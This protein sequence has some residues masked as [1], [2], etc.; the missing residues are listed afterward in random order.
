M[1]PNRLEILNE[2]ADKKIRVLWITLGLNLTVSLAKIILGFAT[3]LLNIIAD[4][5]HSAG[6]TTSNIIGIFGIKYS[7]KPPDKKYPYGYSKIE[8]VASLMIGNILIIA[9]ALMLIETKDRFLNPKNYSFGTA[10]FA[11]MAAT[12]LIN[13]FVAIYELK[14][15][16]ELKSD[17]LKS[18]AKHTITDVLIS[19]SVIAGLAVIKLKG[20]SVLD[21]IMSAA[22]A[23]LIGK[24]VWGIYKDAI[25]ILC[26][27]N[28]I[29]QERIRELALSVP[30]I[31][32]CHAERSRGRPDA[33]FIELHILVNRLMTVGDA[34]DGV[35]HKV[36]DLFQREFGYGLQ[37]LSTHIEPDTE[38]ARGRS[39]SIFKEGDY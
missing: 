35:S 28:Y 5:I 7:K 15:S 2:M 17:F 14:K 26:D 9:M 23:V 39:K 22:I 19:T 25:P 38:E 31:R 29:P 18:D 20:W 21:P 34:H 27:A 24:A 36:K 37:N 6:D 33:F 3:G 10:T 4:G 11:I 30:E 13:V 12:M 1:A 8:T 32:D 16:K